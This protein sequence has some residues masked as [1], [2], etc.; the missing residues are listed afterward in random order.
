[1]TAVP[2]E[3]SPFPRSSRRRAELDAQKRVSALGCALFAAAFAKQILAEKPVTR[4][5]AKERIE[6]LSS[7]FEP[8]LGSGYLDAEAFGF[9]SDIYGT[10]ASALSRAALDLKPLTRITTG[11]SLPSSLLAW[12]L[13]GD[14]KRMDEIVIRGDIATPFFM[15]T[16]VE[17][18]QP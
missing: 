8:L 14:T 9:I 18:E 10:S 13:Y 12:Q 3:I 7:V 1:M 4:A 11:A 5:E 17:A 6:R 16:S 2:V 15:P